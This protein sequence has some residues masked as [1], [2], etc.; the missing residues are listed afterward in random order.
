MGFSLEIAFLKFCSNLPG[1]WVINILLFQPSFD[2][3][4]DVP[5]CPKRTMQYSPSSVPFNTSR[6]MLDDLGL[7]PTQFATQDDFMEDFVF[8]TAFSSNHFRRGF[9]RY[10]P[11]TGVLSAQQNSFLRHWTEWNWSVFRK[12]ASIFHIH[13]CVTR[14]RLIWKRVHFHAFPFTWSLQ[15]QLRHFVKGFIFEKNKI[16]ATDLNNIVWVVFGHKKR[17]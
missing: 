12:C 16:R 2:S 7:P 11:R 3:L 4:F 14:P 13:V 6:T 8:V 15:A 17:H 10:L 9:V 1:Q 5:S